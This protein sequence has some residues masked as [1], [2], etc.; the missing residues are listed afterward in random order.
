MQRNEIGPLGH[1]IVSRAEWLTAR[2][3]L[4]AAEKKLTRQRD[5][6]ARWRRELPWV[7]VEKA[8]AF[9]TQ[10]GQRRL[11]ELFD[12]RSQLIVKHFMLGPGWKDGCV[13]CSF[14]VDHVGGALTHLSN[15]DVTYVAVSRAPLAEIEPFRRRMGWEFPWVSSF[16]SEF[17]FDFGVSFSAKE[18]AAGKV[19]Y[20]YREED[21]PVQELSGHSVF[22]KDEQG[23]VYHTYSAYGRGLEE[24]LGTYMLLDVTPRGR[25]ENGPRKNLTD[26]VRHH[27][28]YGAGGHVDATGRYV[29]PEPADGPCCRNEARS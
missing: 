16:G 3:E 8:Y 25:N 4:L 18:I 29:A 11:S 1:R 17:N 13:G 21:I 28:R 2:K 19:T 27:D 6:L 26:W 5:E 15:H 20:N 10:Q 23:D 12:G 22:F 24:L 9:E 7:K 14:E